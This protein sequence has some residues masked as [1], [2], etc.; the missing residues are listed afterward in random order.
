MESGGVHF[1]NIISSGD[2][3]LNP[4]L[5]F[6]FL[7]PAKNKEKPIKCLHQF[8]KIGGELKIRIHQ[9]GGATSTYNFIGGD[10]FWLVEL[11]VYLEE[12]WWSRWL[13]NG[14]AWKVG[15]VALVVC[16]LSGVAWKVGGVIKQIGGGHM[17]VGGGHMKVSGVM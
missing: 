14:V 9:L 1:S 10:Q 7:A 8:L 2:S 16:L 17:K 6:I 13:L 12:G 3:I 15:G 11:S 4:T 5:N